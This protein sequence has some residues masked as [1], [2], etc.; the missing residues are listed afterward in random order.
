MFAGESNRG[1]GRRY[2][3]GDANLDGAVDGSDFGI[4]NAKQFTSN[5]AWSRGDCNADGAVDGSNFGIWNDNKFTAFDRAGRRSGQGEHSAVDATTRYRE[6]TRE[7]TDDDLLTPA[8]PIPPGWFV[9]SGT[10][11]VSSLA[12]GPLAA[13]INRVRIFVL[14]AIFFTEE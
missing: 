6:D 5:A 7:D 11:R 14:S 13:G 4:W 8:Q 3:W 9:V 10:E 2:R 12:V 1:V